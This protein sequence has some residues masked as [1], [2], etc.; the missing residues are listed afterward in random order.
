[1]A[2]ARP[3]REEQ[4]KP[5]EEQQNVWVRFARDVVL[6]TFV[7]A[8]AVARAHDAMVLVVKAQLCRRPS[9]RRNFTE[10]SA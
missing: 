5:P 7:G 3:S 4:T 8:Y 2:G 9:I 1:M 10:S 6:D